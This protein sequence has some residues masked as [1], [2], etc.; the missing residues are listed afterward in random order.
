MKNLNKKLGIIALS[1]IKG[2][3]PAFI[4][5][6]LQE[7]SFQSSSI[8]DDILILLKANNKNIDNETILT[9]I[10]IATK[11]VN[12]CTKEDIFIIEISDQDYPSQLKEIKDPP[13]ILFCKGNLA[14]LRHKTICIIGTRAPNKNGAVIAQ[15]TGANYSSFGFAICNGLAAGIDSCAIKTTSDFHKNVIGVLAGGLNFNSGSTLLKVIAKNAAGV[16][17]NG[18]LVIS[19]YPPN[20]KEDTFSVVKSCRIQAGISQGLILVQSS[21]SGGSRFTVKA[22]CET[23]RPIAVIKPVLSDYDLLTYEANKE[24]LEK[25][26]KG[27][28]K[29]TELKDEKILTKEI[30]AIK[31]KEDFSK[32]E[33]IV[34][35]KEKNSDKAELTLF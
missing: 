9:G 11:I 5:K 13:P 15:K 1:S 10:N 17:E 32:F 27:L 12:E 16:L 3:G 29:F 8:L 28:S 2:I 21:L 22:Y 20:K 26:I 18:G 7:T 19:E 25:G 30:F 35:N 23:S 33:E 4:K 34:R 31:T 14:L 24:I 6:S